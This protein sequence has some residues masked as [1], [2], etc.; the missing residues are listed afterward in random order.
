MIARRYEEQLFQ[1]L[2]VGRLLAAGG[3]FVQ[4]G[5]APS[6][7]SVL[8]STKEPVQVADVKPVVEV[9]NKLIRRYKYLTSAR[10]GH[11]TAC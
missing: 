4:D 8:G 2:L 11:S 9:F 6:P 1:L 3:G 5:A 10:A 7:F